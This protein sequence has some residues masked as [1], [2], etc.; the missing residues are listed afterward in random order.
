MD[1]DSTPVDPVATCPACKH[2]GLQLGETRTLEHAVELHL[3]C[4]ACGESSVLTI[5]E[6]PDPSG[7]DDAATLTCDGI[8]GLRSVRSGERSHPYRSICNH[9]QSGG[10]LALSG[11]VRWRA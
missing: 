7:D 5:A 10:S 4:R 6:T 1:R 8:D 2:P 3:W 9:L 11:C